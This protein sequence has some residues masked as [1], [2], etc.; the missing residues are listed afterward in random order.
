MRKIAAIAVCLVA[1]ATLAKP[2]ST[3]WEQNPNPHPHGVGRV[4]PH[5]G[6]TWDAIPKGLK[7]WETR[8]LKQEGDKLYAL[9]LKL[10]HGRTYGKAKSNKGAAK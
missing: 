3:R 6:Q 2:V 1:L 4:C 9:H 5:C 10:R 8:H 7:A